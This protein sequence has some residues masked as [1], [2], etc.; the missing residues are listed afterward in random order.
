MKSGDDFSEATG[1]LRKSL[2]AFFAFGNLSK[3]QCASSR[4]LD[5]TKSGDGLFRERQVF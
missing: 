2:K 3:C 5:I 1:I 4:R